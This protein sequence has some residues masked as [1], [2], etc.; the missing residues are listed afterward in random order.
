VDQVLLKSW[1]TAVQ[2]VSWR[3]FE[4]EENADFQPV[5]LGAA[6]ERASLRLLAGEGQKLGRKNGIYSTQKI[7]DAAR[8]ARLP[9]P[10]EGGGARLSC[11]HS[12]NTVLSSGGGPPHE[13]RNSYAQLW[14]FALA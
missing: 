11:F 8:A 9:T 2:I 10:R 4:A 14:G 7:S 5:K 13:A 12:A 6:R 1:K 3:F